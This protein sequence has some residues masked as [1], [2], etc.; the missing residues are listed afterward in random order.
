MGTN[1]LDPRLRRF[2]QADMKGKVVLIRV[3]H[4]VVKGGRIKDP[5]RI[6]A[7]LGTL[8]GV[9]RR[10]GKPILMTH[11][12]RP[13]DK[14]TGKIQCRDRESVLPIVRYLEGK[15]SA[16]IL[17][18]D[19]AVDPERGILE[20]GEATR[21]AVE[22]LRAD[23][24]DMVYLP[25]TRWFQGEQAKG[26]EREALAEDLADLADLFVNDAFGSWQAH[27]STFD[28]AR[29]LPAYAGALMQKELA[30]LERVLRPEKPFVG[31][32]AGAKYDTKIGP[33][34][35]LHERADAL[36]LGGLMYNTYLA[37]KYNLK[38]G[39][40]T[41]EDR[42]LARELV[43]LDQG[44]DKILE[45]PRVV[46]SET[47]EGRVDGRYRTVSLE[48]LRRRGRADFIVDVDP[49]S[50]DDQRVREVVG[51]AGTFFINAVM[52]YMPHFFEGSRALYR[53]AASNEQAAKLY[54]GGDTLQEFKALCPGDYLRGLDAEGTYYFTGGGSVLAAIEQGTPY[55]LEP[56]RVLM[57]AA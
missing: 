33:L 56:V 32:I 21:N 2:E 24:V 15:L 40:V 48:E 41:P 29:R 35:A 36:I 7:T 6:D 16:R 3:D 52:G 18:P 57:E 19:C 43:A 11:V 17:V 23:K 8:F 45:L 49:A 51:S 39:G 10:G 22:A 14:K 5:Y 25:N 47:M 44:K 12:G 13:R 38:I 46:E 27:V 53:M 31:V 28:V 42:D 4:N 50:F 30:N 54:G 1:V 9:A 37:A 34:R 55:G 20:P 26:P